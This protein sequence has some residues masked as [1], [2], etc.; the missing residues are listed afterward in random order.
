M[1]PTD[2]DNLAE[3]F[4]EARRKH[5]DASGRTDNASVWHETNIWIFRKL[6]EM[7]LRINELESDL[8]NK[9]GHIQ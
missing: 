5:I 4:H 9:G 7:Q 6:A 1:T 8:E 3:Q 2:I